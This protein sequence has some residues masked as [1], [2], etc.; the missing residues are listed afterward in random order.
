MSEKVKKQTT[1]IDQLCRYYMDFLRSG[2]KNTKFPKRYI[3]LVNEKGF[4]IGVDLSKYEKFN[5]HIKKLINKE[6]NLQN[7]INIKKGEF[8]VKLN[9]TSQDLIKKLVKKIQSSLSLDEVLVT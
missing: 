7:T 4:K 5:S 9:N 3:R 2:F 6:N 8:S 1:F